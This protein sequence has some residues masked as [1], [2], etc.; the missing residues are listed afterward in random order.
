MK[1][2]DKA[3]VVAEIE[4]KL[5]DLI[6]C[7]KDAFYPEERITLQARINMCKEILSF[8]ETLEVKEDNLLTEIEKELAD[9]WIGR[10]DKKRIPIELKGELKAKFKNEFHTMWQTVGALQFANA[11]KHIMERLCLHFSAWGAYNLKD[12]GKISLEERQKM[13]VEIKN[14]DLEKEIEIWENS[15]KHCPAS[16][17]YKETAKHFFEFGLKAQKGR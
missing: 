14:V 5:Q 17:K 7:K 16:M 2:I 12:I 9:S 4:K 8:L 13:D 3:V 6:A 10:I 15:F 11:A 1:L